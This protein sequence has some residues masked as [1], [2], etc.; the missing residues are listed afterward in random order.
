MIGTRKAP[1]SARS[2]WADVSHGTLS[3]ATD[4]SFSYSP[5]PDYYGSDSFTYLANNS[6]KESN[7][8]TVRIQ[9]L[10]VNDGPPTANDQD[11][12]T[13]RN[14]PL[15]ITLTASDDG[16]WALT[17]E[18]LTQPASGSLSGAA[19]N[20]VYTPNPGFIGSDSFTFKA[21]DGEFDSNIATVRI[22]V[23]PYF[24]VFLPLI[25]K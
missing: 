4:G 17:F 6:A 8:A 16:G 2:W 14:T 25:F 1:H 13:N 21:N 11:V 15:N 12:S 23:L 7:I 19:P 18:V 10:P 5:A 9:V 3:L 20:L 24:P 22:E